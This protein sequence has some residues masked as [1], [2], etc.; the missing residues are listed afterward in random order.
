[1]EQ[2]LVSFAIMVLAVIVAVWILP[3][4]GKLAIKAG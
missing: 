2:F 3:P 1:M 4:F